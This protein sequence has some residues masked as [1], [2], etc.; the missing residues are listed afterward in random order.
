MRNCKRCHGVGKYSYPNEQLQDCLYC[1]ATGIFEPVDESQIL[2]LIIATRGKN[3][4]K[5]RGSMT[6][7][8]RSDGVLKNRAYYVWRMARFHG[9]VDITMPVMASTCINNDPYRDE[10]DLLADKVA[11][12]SFGSNMRASYRWGRAL[13]MIDWAFRE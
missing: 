11:V 10:L 5:L 4:D 2:A 6:S 8:I 3:K 1:N 7:P 12:L 9:G 13:G